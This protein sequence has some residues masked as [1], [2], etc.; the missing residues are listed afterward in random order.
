VPHEQERPAAVRVR[1]AHPREH[2]RA[3]AAYDA[4]GYDGG[5]H[6]ADTV[7]VAEEEPGGELVGVV[8]LTLEE[9]TRMLRGMQV[10]PR[11]QRRGVGTQLLRAL[12]ARLGRESCYCVPYAHLVD[13]YGRAGFAEQP[14]AGAPAFLVERLARYRGE[15]L[16]VTLMR[17]PGAAVA[18]GG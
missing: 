13:F 7:L 16:A 18:G 11:A 10:A 1:V 14:L 12:V 4:W 8:R 5:V 9:G 2:A 3:R 17:R 6:P 15:G